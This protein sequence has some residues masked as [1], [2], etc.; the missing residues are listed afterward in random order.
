MTRRTDEI[1][2]LA[3]EIDV[4]ASNAPAS[5]ETRLL[6]VAAKALVRLADECDAI[7]RTLSSRTDHLV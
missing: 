1:R 5:T 6:V 7:S 4:S 3:E 2:D